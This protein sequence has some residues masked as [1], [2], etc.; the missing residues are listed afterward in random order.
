MHLSRFRIRL[1]NFPADDSIWPVQIGLIHPC[2]SSELKCVLCS[3]ANRFQTQR[4]DLT[5]NDWSRPVRNVQI[6]INWIPQFNALCNVMNWRIFFC[7]STSISLKTR[8][9]ESTRANRQRSTEYLPSC[10]NRHPVWRVVICCDELFDSSRIVSNCQHF[11]HC[12]VYSILTI[13]FRSFHAL[14]T[15]KVHVVMFFYHATHF[16]SLLTCAPFDFRYVN[17]R[18]DSLHTMV[19][20]HIAYASRLPV[21]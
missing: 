20:S 3:S 1:L 18:F 19:I 6:R 7:E 16:H 21:C 8:R 17:A 9:V 14:R 10:A 13:D 12:M 5:K 15:W 2:E 4:T 11:L